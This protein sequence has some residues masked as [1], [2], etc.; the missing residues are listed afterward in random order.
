VYVDPRITGNIGLVYGSEI[1]TSG[2]AYPQSPSNHLDRQTIVLASV[3]LSYNSG[4]KIASIEDKRVFIRPGPLPLSSLNKDGGG[5]GTAS[6]L[7]NDLISGINTGNLPVTNMGALFARDP[8]GLG[9]TPDGGG[10][11]HLFY[12]SDAA[13][14]QASGGSYQITPV[15]RTSLK[16]LAWAPG[17]QKVVTFG[18]DILFKP[19]TSQDT[20][21][22]YLLDILAYDDDASGSKKYLGHL[23]QTED[24]TVSSSAITIPA[25]SQ[26]STAS[27][28][29]IRY[30]HAG[31]T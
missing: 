15:H 25:N 8:V 19:L 30:I 10:Q 26:Y 5:S 17:S 21:S 27:H 2:G 16:H 7:A 29:E 14:G 18:T 22:L 31:H 6:S 1:D 28:I 3:R 12:Q 23:V 24:Y 11:T 9:G 4:V 13:V 20:N